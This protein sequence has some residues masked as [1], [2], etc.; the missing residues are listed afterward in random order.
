MQEV[1]S[2]V[3]TYFKPTFSQYQT[4][5]ERKNFRK[6]FL[7]RIMP[8]EKRDCSLRQQVVDALACHT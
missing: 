7:Y 6:I 3:A 4:D 5:E 8:D 1:T 2:K